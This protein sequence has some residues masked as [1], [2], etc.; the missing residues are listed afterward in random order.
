MD[1][2][3]SQMKEIL[4]EEEKAMNG[5]EWNESIGT[6]EDTCSEQLCSP[7]CYSVNGMSFSVHSAGHWRSLLCTFKKITSVPCPTV[8]LKSSE[9]WGQSKKIYGRVI[10]LRK[11]NILGFNT[12]LY[13]SSKITCTYNWRNYWLISAIKR[14][15]HQRCKLMPSL[16]IQVYTWFPFTENLHVAAVVCE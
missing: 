9:R 4:A 10:R 2:W 16:L 8:L 12:F 13:D 6:Q 7:F 15:I 5:T 11:L 1:D 3:T 14:C